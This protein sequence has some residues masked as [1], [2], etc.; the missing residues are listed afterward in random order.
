MS[1]KGM[2]LRHS[3]ILIRYF[4]EENNNCYLNFGTKYHHI[5]PQKCPSYDL[6]GFV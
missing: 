3:C 1:Q 2:R 4:C 5:K 6:N